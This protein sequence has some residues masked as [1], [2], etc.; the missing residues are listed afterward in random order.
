MAPH[1]HTH[2]VHLYTLLVR[3][4]LHHIN[5]WVNKAVHK[6][7][8]VRSACPAPFLSSP[9]LLLHSASWERLESSAG[10]NK[11]GCYAR[12]RERERE[13]KTERDGDD[14]V[15]PERSKLHRWRARD[16]VKVKLL[17]Q[18]TLQDALP[19]AICTLLYCL[20]PATHLNNGSQSTLVRQ[21]AQ[22]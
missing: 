11:A 19:P 3:K 18:L 14:D 20:V 2:T 15:T 10:A 5:L 4:A 13:I 22:L 7:R 12:T 9:G 17:K 16:R 6:V 8:L 1:R 21:W